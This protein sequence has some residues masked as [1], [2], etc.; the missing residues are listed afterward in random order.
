MTAM[1]TGVKNVRIT[2][3]NIAHLL[4]GNPLQIRRE[5]PGHMREVVRAAV[6]TPAPIVAQSASIAT[7]NPRLRE[8]ITTFR[9][10]GSMVE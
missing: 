8:E 1:A 10:G 3:L 6:H 2:R 7:A 4:V 9:D 5:N